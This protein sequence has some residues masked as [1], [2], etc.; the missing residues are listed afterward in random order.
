MSNHSE[1][2][3]KANSL[4]NY[5]PAKLASAEAKRIELKVKIKEIDKRMDT[6]VT[7]PCT[8][9]RTFTKAPAPS[10]SVFNHLT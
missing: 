6:K 1:I 3:R 4:I 7:K 9:A 8:K 5:W 2:L 10:C